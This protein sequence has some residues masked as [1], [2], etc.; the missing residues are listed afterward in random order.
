MLANSKEM[1]T[2]RCYHQ[3]IVW[4]PQANFSARIWRERT[5]IALL[6]AISCNHLP[7]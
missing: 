1:K 6:V 5:V 3:S 2:K 7:R 4:R